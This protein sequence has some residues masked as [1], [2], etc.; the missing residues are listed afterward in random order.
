MYRNVFV[1]L[2]QPTNHWTGHTND[3][4]QPTTR[5]SMED[6][7]KTTRQTASQPLAHPGDG[8]GTTPSG[9]GTTLRMG[10]CECAFVSS[11][12]LCV[13]RA[14]IPTTGRSAPIDRAIHRTDQAASGAV[15]IR[16]FPVPPQSRDRVFSIWLLHGCTPSGDRTKP[17]RRSKWAEHTPLDDRRARLIT[18]TPEKMSR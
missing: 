1:Y 15:W 3:D 18:T 8:G 9:D 7:Q 14:S 2:H 10:T 16:F 4:K 12:I 17:E 13:R 5:N 11:I 6:N